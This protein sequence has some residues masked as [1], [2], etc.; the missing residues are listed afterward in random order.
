MVS[1]TAIFIDIAA[2][3]ISSSVFPVMSKPVKCLIES[4]IVTLAYGALKLI[5]WSPKV[6][7]EVPF[8][9][10]AQYSNNCSANSII[11]L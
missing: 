7:S 4:V 11:Q 3:L 8:T 5:L 1:S 6:A 10:I 2:A 9:A